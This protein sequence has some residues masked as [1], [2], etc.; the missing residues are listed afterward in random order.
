MMTIVM[1]AVMVGQLQ[2]AG[3]LYGDPFADVFGNQVRHISS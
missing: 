3:V 1:M 2:L